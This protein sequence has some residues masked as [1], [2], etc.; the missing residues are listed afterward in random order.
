M[1]FCAWENTFVCRNFIY[2]SNYNK[3]WFVNTSWKWTFVLQIRIKAKGSCYKHTSIAWKTLV[4]GKC[5][6]G[7]VLH[8]WDGVQ[9]DP[10]H[11]AGWKRRSHQREGGGGVRSWV[12]VGRV[13]V[14]TGPLIPHLQKEP[15]LK[16]RSLALPAHSTDDWW[17]IS[18]STHQS[19]QRARESVRAPAWERKREKM[20]K[21]C[22]DRGQEKK[23][24]HQT[25]DLVTV[26]AYSNFWTSK[27]GTFQPDPH[28]QYCESR[29]PPEFC[30]ENLLLKLFGK[31]ILL[32]DSICSG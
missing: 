23:V 2:C 1:L 4:S 12:G 7:P 31:R 13:S 11:S 15:C 25:D 20:C 5:G 17:H 16:W 21:T 32:T 18:S 28:F 27:P 8:F 29:H 30:P 3:R 14:R 10:R 19:R 26:T 22:N 6:V 9:K 24:S